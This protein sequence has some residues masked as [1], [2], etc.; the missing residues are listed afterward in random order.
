MAGVGAVGRADSCGQAEFGQVVQQGDRVRG[1][2]PCRG[3][4]VGF[5]REQSAASVTAS[6]VQD[7]GDPVERAVDAAARVRDPA[8]VATLSSGW[9][10][11]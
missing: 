11:L 10:S 7:G 2:L 4:A 5:G 8:Q 6:R 3:D 1:R 9:I